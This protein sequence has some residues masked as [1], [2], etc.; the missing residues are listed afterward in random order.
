MI[1]L[2]RIL[3]GIIMPKKI[4]SMSEALSNPTRREILLY[5]ME[6][7]G[8]SARRISRDLD[9]SIGNLYNHLFILNRLGVLKIERK[10]NGRKFSI[11]LNQHILIRR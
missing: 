2:L 1:V 7:P 11:Y 5:V 3:M 8:V 9:I 4:L 10:N 6:N